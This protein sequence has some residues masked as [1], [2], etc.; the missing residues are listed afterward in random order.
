[1][2]EKL[3]IIKGRKNSWAGRAEE[4]GNRDCPGKANLTGPGQW[5]E[6]TASA[7]AG[8][9]DG[10]GLPGKWDRAGW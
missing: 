7:L 6:S 10:I 2:K 3:A 1:M 9:T 4:T 5:P 8:G